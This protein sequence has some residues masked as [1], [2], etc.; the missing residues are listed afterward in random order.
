[1]NS[2]ENKNW[3]I[4]RRFVMALIC[5][6]LLLLLNAVCWAQPKPKIT[7]QPDPFDPAKS[8]SIVLSIAKTDGAKPDLDIKGV[9]TV[10]VGDKTVTFQS[11][12]A[13]GTVT[14]TDPPANL[15]GQQKVKLLGSTGNLLGEVQLTYPSGGGSNG[16]STPTTDL[17]RLQA[18][19][20]IKRQNDLVS[21][22][23]YFFLIVV[24]FS[25][26]LGAFVG[27]IVRA[28]LRSRAT[29]RSPLGMPVGSFRAIIAYTLVAF[30]GFYVMTSLLTVSRFAPP[31]FL[32]G[33]VATV[34]GFYFGSRTGEEGGVDEKAGTV[35]GIVRKDT[36]VSG[37]PVSGASVKFKRDDGTEPYSRI[38]DVDGGF[39]LQGAK[40]GK[41]KVS[42]TVTGSTTS[43]QLDVNITE[44]SDQEIE[45]VIKSAAAAGAGGATG[46]QGGGAT[47]GGAG[48]GGA[49]GGGTQPAVGSVKG[50][51]TQ[52]DGKTAAVGA[53]IT[54]TGNKTFTAQSV[55][56]GS[57]KIDKVD[58]GQYTAVATS[59]NFA[60]SKSVTVTVTA[61][62]AK[63]LDLKL[64]TKT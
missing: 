55:E 61:G 34:I 48:G 23:W 3:N 46:G 19:S 26:M 40:A 56:G 13:N 31:D 21:N 58:A 57:Y 53:T 12:E 33:I 8:K 42:A 41:Y 20:E 7:A 25:L 51:V 27:T 36:P 11:D 32:L 63:Q 43:G 5:P 54:L 2:A 62:D 24:A 35:R 9:N 30:L 18:E 28:I 10:I 22:W 29:F 1:M 4:R 52:P 60:P 39:V 64:E 50:T 47:G 37:A 15:T 44:G 16:N 17:T 45:I 49:A 59:P 6:A 38:T 14:I